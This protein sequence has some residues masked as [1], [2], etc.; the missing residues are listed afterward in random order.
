MDILIF[1]KSIV[2]PVQAQ[3]LAY[4]VTANL[5]LGIL[6]ALITVKFEI[7]RLADF[8]KRVAIVFGVYL[9]VAI[10]VK[11]MADF[12]P[13]RLAIWIALIGYLVSQILGNIKDILKKVGIPLPDG[14]MQWVERQPEQPKTP[15][16]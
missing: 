14:L 11:A 2:D 5:I 10:A 4:L 7:A 9:A 13:L 3:T 12:E 8:G 15:P 16:A 1:L 6:A